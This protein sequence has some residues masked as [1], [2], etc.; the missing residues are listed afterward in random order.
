MGLCKAILRVMRQRMLFV[1]RTAY[2]TAALITG[3]HFDNRAVLVRFEAQNK[4]RFARRR[5]AR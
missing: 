3:R 5:S 2:R 1:R 4:I